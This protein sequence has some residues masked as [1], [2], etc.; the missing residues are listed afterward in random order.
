MA[1]ALGLMSGTSCDGVSAAILEAPRLR[2][3]VHR[4]RPYP[5]ELRRRL[6]AAPRASA[7][8]ICRL[9]ARLGDEFAR[10]ARA[11]ARGRRVAVVGSHGHTVWHR[12]RG[13]ERG[14]LQIGDASRIAEALGVP[15]VCDFRSRD[16]A[17][18]GQGAPLVPAFDAAVW[19][20]GPPRV[21]LNLGGIANLTLV[22]RGVRPLAFDTGPA[23]TLLD[24]AVRRLTRGQPAIDRDGRIAA[25]GRVDLAYWRRLS[26]HPFLQR[27]PPKS[28]GREEFGADLLPRRIT[29]DVVAT[30][31]FFT[32]A[33]VAD[34]IRRWVLPRARPVEVLVSGGGAANPVV[35]EHLRRR[36]WP[37]SV[38]RLADRGWPD[39]A[40]E[41]AAFAYLAWLTLRR[42]PGNAPWATG[43]RRAVV[44][45]SVVPE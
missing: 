42:R 3:V 12:P 11:L 19:G 32:A 39:Q 44:L 23:N 38:A 20:S 21:L 28:T 2:L 22:G 4:T 13:V 29:P 36:L 10:T 15:V 37:I 8:E 33:S 17:A 43:A 45:G 40:K 27:A 1:L 14:T 9:H 24:E 18:G 41:P 7:E 34:A 30:L 31:A 26:A 35:M 5:P 16:V 6:L 25:S